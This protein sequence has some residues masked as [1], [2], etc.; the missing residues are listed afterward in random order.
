VVQ[1]ELGGI[2]TVLQCENYVSREDDVSAVHVSHRIMIGFADGNLF[3]GEASGPALWLSSGLATTISTQP[4]WNH[5]SSALPL[6]FEAFQ[7]QRDNA[8]RLAIQR[9]ES[10][11]ETGVTPA[12]QAREYLL[13]ISRAWRAAANCLGPVEV[14]GDDAAGTQ[15]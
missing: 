6:T 13:D 4:A 1:G 9:I 2:P 5:V 3:L 7:L 10:E 12:I 8:N 11:I 15:V 14:I